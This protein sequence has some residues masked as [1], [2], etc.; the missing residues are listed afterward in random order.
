M[1]DEAEGACEEL[2]PRKMKAKLKRTRSFEAA[3]AA[4]AW[5]A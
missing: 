2:G 5:Y 4:S 3:E 1:V